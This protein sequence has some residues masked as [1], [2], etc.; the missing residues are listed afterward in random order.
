MAHSKLVSF[1]TKRC[2]KH[3]GE[4]IN[5]YCGD[6]DVV[7]ISSCKVLEHSNCSKTKHLIDA[8]KGVQK[9]K[10][11]QTIKQDDAVRVLADRKA[12]I[13]RI[14]NE[15]KDV[16]KIIADFRKK[17]NKYFDDLEQK[18]LDA[19][20]KK[21]E[22]IV[23]SCKQNTEDL[24]VMKSTTEDMLKQLESFKG[25]NEC[26]LFV[27][28]KTDKKFLSN[29]MQEVLNISKK[30][31]KDAINFRIDPKIE[32]YVSSL[33]GLGTFTDIPVNVGQLSLATTDR[34]VSQSRASA[35]S[36]QTFPDNRDP[37]PIFKTQL[38][39]KFDVKEKSDS[40]VC[41]I[42]GICQLPDGNILIADCDN[43]KLKRLDQSYKLPDSLR[44]PGGPY[45]I[46]NVGSDEI[47]VYLPGAKKVHYISVR[48]ELTLTRSF[49]TVNYCR[50]MVYVDNKLYVC[51]GD[52]CDSASYCIKVYNNA[53]R[54]QHSISGLSSVP[55]YI[56][57]TD[58]GQHLLVTSLNSDNITMMDLTGNVVNT[59][60][61]R[62]LKEPYG[63]CTDCKGLVF[64][65]GWKSITVVQL[66]PK[67]QKID[68]ILGEKDGIKNPWAIY[69]D[70][71]Q[72][73]VLI[74]CYQSNQ[75]MPTKRRTKSARGRGRTMPALP[76]EVQS[77][78]DPATTEE[79]ATTPAPSIEGI[80]SLSSLPSSDLGSER[81]KSRDSPEINGRP[82][83]M[84]ILPRS[85]RM[86]SSNGLN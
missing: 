44:L 78:P 82:K 34:H 48:K 54:L 59:F 42:T 3:P 71:K 61:N 31:R 2:L 27:Q 28:V 10:E 7:C 46:C 51:R 26:D 80:S 63:K 1:P 25:D 68:V 53:G 49:S 69:Y 66:E 22:I 38:Y 83:N 60:S 39:G 18:T 41:T 43:E 15:R 50:G 75:L 72:S 11:Y 23:S 58:D 47:A 52:L 14:E 29:A 13:S 32:P 4:I 62:D 19:L 36:P 70:R 64:I 40:N 37:L 17:V 81:R 6:H 57:V 85:R 20:H 5:I 79:V 21:A 67:Q 35:S 73:R 77:A 74:S 12:D 30:V 84:P 33:E 76:L 8:A 45:S 16:K 86:T 9:S 65:C 55:A 24:T 56:T